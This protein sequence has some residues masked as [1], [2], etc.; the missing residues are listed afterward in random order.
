MGCGSSVQT[1]NLTP[2]QPSMPSIQSFPKDAKELTGSSNEGSEQSEEAAAQE[3]ARLEKEI[4]PNDDKP[5]QEA[6]DMIEDVGDFEQRLEKERNNQTIL[7]WLRTALLTAHQSSK[8]K[9]WIKR[10]LARNDFTSNMNFIQILQPLQDH[11]KEELLKI[12]GPLHVLYEQE[13]Y[14]QKLATFMPPIH[15]KLLDQQ[16]QSP[17]KISLRQDHEIIGLAPSSTMNMEDFDG[18]SK[19]IHFLRLVAYAVNAEYQAIIKKIVTPLH[20]DH[21]GCAIKGDARM[22]NKALAPDDH[23]YEPKPRPALNIDIVRCC[24]TFGTPKLLI[25]GVNALVTAFNTSGGGIGRI[26]NGFALTKEEAAT[27]FH[28]R[29][30]MVN[31]VVDFDCTYG[32]LCQ[33]NAVVVMLNNYLNAPPENPKQPWCQW[34]R[35]AAAAVDYFKSPAMATQRVTMVCEVQ[36]LLRPYL[37]AREQMHLLYNIV[38]AKL[39]IHLAQQFAV[40]VV[41]D[42]PN[43]ATLVSEQ[44]RLLAKIQTDVARHNT[45][46]LSNACLTGFVSAVQVALAVEDVDVNQT[47]NGGS[48]PMYIAS[49]CGHLDV[50]E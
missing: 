33:R 42:R 25:N 9:G 15:P 49:M 10:V 17:T 23:R 29:S 31:F 13:K 14:G 11:C 45:L 36:F 39:D 19:Y 27:S 16:N 7:T 8:V 47:D 1:S 46:A 35:D 38:R 37:K 20:G 50:V 18:E 30:Y 40:S 43:N 12:G 41:K 5:I 21:K 2:V 48:T 6:M 4:L 28:Y 3:I 22:R 32:E 26:K 24:V 34:K 44:K